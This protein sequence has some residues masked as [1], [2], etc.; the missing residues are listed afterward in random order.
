VNSGR[1]RVDI[2]S[3]P[4]PTPMW[5]FS[6]NSRVLKRPVLVRLPCRSSFDAV[7]EGIT[8]SSSS[9]NVDVLNVDNHRGR[10]RL[11]CYYRGYQNDP[12]PSQ[13]RRGT[14][15]LIRMPCRLDGMA[16]IRTDLEFVSR[17]E[18]LADAGGYSLRGRGSSGGVGWD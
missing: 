4:I 5:T 2:E 17:S 8:L 12:W 18:H 6:S 3:I 1:L 16:E 15:T 11:G 9:S 13:R 10:W 14:Y 7:G